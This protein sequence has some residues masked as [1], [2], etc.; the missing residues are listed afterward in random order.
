MPMMSRLLPRR[1][2]TARGVAKGEDARALDGCEDADGSCM[3]TSFRSYADLKSSA[4]RRPSHYT[5]FAQER[6]DT[7]LCWS[8]ANT[9]QR[10]TIAPRGQHDGGGGEVKA[11]VGGA[12]GPPE[13]LR[14]AE[15]EQPAP[16]AGQGAIRVEACGVSFPDAVS[17]QGKY[18]VRP[19]LPFTPGSEVAGVV[20]AL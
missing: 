17:V 6:P 19:P 13:R 1:V 11:V 9:Q 20:T 4:C 7:L 2:G 5:G 18:Q 8:A 10:V 16:G 15:V 14:G 3:G 12:E